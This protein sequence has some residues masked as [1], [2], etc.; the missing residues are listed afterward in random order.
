MK[1]KFLLPIIASLIFAN[2]ANAKMVL[3]SND[4]AHKQTLSDAQVF[5]SFGCM[6]KNISPH[7]SWEGAPIGTKS[8][9]LMVYDPDAPT[10]SGWWH[11]VAFNIP[12]DTNELAQN[13]G[14]NTNS[15]NIIQSRT[16]FGTYGFGGACPPQGDKPHRYQ[17]TIYALGVESLPIDKDASAAMVGFMVRANALDKATIEAKFGRKK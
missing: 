17:F 5:N 11:W 12:K 8:Y 2:A 13:F 16:D 1:I 7:L 10:G 15:G 4:I 9:A 6:G 3:K 14:A